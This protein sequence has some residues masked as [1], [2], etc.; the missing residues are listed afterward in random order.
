MS[1][2]SA[3]VIPFGVP[4]EG[5]GLGLGLAAL[6]HALARVDESGVA[7]ARL[8]PRPDERVAVASGAP[9][10][11]AFVPPSAWRD[12][13]GL[14]EEPSGVRIVI[15]GAFE[16]PVRGHGSIRLLAFDARDGRTRAH[17]EASVD[18]E[19]AGAALVAAFGRLWAGLS[20]DIGA[21]RELGELEWEPLESVMRAERCLLREPPHGGPHN[22]LAAMLH[23][24]RAIADAPDANYPAHRLAAVALEAGSTRDP[25]LAT[26]AARALERAVADAPSRV[27][28]AEALAAVWLRLGRSHDAERSANAA[29]AAAPAR[30]PLYAL[31]AQALRA[32]GDPDGALAVLQTA[33]ADADADVLLC[34]ERG[35]ALAQRGDLDG[36]R[37]AW[38]RAFARGAVHPG[39]FGSLAA[40]ALRLGD[41]AA[42]QSLID[43]ALASPRAH[44]EVLQH[45][46]WLALRTEPQGLARASRVARLSERILEQAPDDP[47]ASLALA[48]SLVALGDRGQ[49][50]RRFEHVERVA[51]GTSAAAEAQAARLAIE[52]PEAEVELRSVLRAAHSAPEMDLGDVAS[53]ARRLATL[54]GSWRGWL[55]AGVAERRRCAWAAAQRALECALEL[56]PGAV[57]VHLELSAVR[58]AMRD[59]AGALSHAERARVLDGDSPQAIAASVRALVA[60]GRVAQADELTRAALLAH[61]GNDEVR[62]LVSHVRRQF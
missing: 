48:R 42:S 9:P 12:V 32:R 23:L 22:R 5:R 25:T 21:L 14:G 29:L 35:V 2:P 7:M 58:M 54:H 40:L 19:R 43:A 45:A 17:I 20:G 46:V 26:A 28:L 57:P 6:V 8:Q 52:E 60:L 31:L 55:A 51:P 1:S 49:A 62:G 44:A 53:R 33:P 15:T 13:A 4:D 34:A 16:P 38:Q 59:A 39:A 41:Q 18:D 30:A 11:E 36:A 24:G 47:L 37:T 50:R 27:E 10:A 61:P 3:V 56:A